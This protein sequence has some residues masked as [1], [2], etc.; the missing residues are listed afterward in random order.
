MYLRISAVKIWD[1]YTII[2]IRWKYID[3]CAKII[4]ARGVRC[5]CWECLVHYF[6]FITM[7][8]E[9]IHVQSTWTEEK[10]TGH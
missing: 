1:E 4:K 6:E 2:H 10:G 8:L 3:R 7:K 9:H 5:V